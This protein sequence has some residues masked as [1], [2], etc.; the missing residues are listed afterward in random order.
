M[1]LLAA[2]SGVHARISAHRVQSNRHT[3]E[4]DEQSMLYCGG[5]L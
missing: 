5:T 3:P 4:T 2:D 1:R